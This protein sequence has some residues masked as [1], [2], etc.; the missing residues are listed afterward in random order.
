[1]TLQQD[2]PADYILSTG[3]THTVRSF[4]EKAAVAIG[5][6][7]EWV[8]RGFE[9]VGVDAISGRKVIAVSKGLH[10]PAEIAPP[11]VNCD[12]ARVRLGWMPEMSFDGLVRLMADTDMARA[13]K[14]LVQ[15]KAVIAQGF[16]SDRDA[17]AL[18]CARA[19]FNLTDPRPEREPFDFVI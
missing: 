7:I 12:T 5:M 9:E 1:M 4:A 15:H 16:G 8:G 14:S 13:R 18:G 3:E 6:N 11:S 17:R 2:Q 10:R 19:G